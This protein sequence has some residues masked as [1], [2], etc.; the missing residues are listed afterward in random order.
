MKYLKKNYHNI[1]PYHSQ[2]IEEGIILN[3]NES[4]FNIPET[5]INK[6]NDCVNSLSFN[7]YPDT[8]ANIL[9][10]ALAKKYK[11]EKNNF[12]CGVG[13]DSLIDCIYKAVLS[14]E[15]IV[16][17]VD[18]T[19]SMYHLYAE[20][21]S[22]KVVKVPLNVDFTYNVENILQAILVNEPKVV[23]LCSP[24]NPTG[25]IIEIKE[26][27]R[28]LN[29][30]KGLVILDEAYGEFIN[31][32]GIPLVNKYENLIILKT[33]SKAYS[34]ASGRVGYAISNKDNI[35][36]I[37]TVKSPY[38]L[39]SMSL[40]MATNIIENSHLYD[41]NIL[42][43]KNECNRVYNELKIM[44]VIVYKSHANFLWMQLDDLVISKIKN[45]NIHIRYFKYNHQNYQRITIGLKE[46]NNRLLGVIK[47]A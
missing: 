35:E 16:L 39:N 41:D 31:N 47:N 24:N 32:S 33:F 14:E 37:N 43:L 15:D 21:Y 34:F 27:E 29:C 40:Y 7:R 8:D 25:S 20:L 19:F 36:M 6:F 44:N 18:P 13:S 23:V 17:T 26:V 4:P 10:S 30:T 42:Y 1:K 22:A 3:G 2:H 11:L 28:I 5:I 38:F 45:S 9:I 46:E 12:T